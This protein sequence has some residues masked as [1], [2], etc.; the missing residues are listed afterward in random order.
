MFKLGSCKQKSA[1]IQLN[2][3][4]GIRRFY[5]LIHFSLGR[6]CTHTA[7]GS[8]IQHLTF[9][10][11]HLNERKV[12]VSSYVCIVFTEG[13]CNMYDTG[14][15]CHSNVLITGYK[16]A[17]LVLLV[18]TN[19][20][21]II[22]RLELFVFQ[23]FTGISFQYFIGFF[24]RAFFYQGRKNAVS[25]CLCQIIGIA[26]F[27]F[28]LYVCLMRVYTKCHVGRQGPRCCGP[29]QEVCIFAQNLEANNSRTLF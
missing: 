18:C 21:T 24:I 19:L 12:I 23:I 5:S 3:N 10:V 26:V 4:F 22:K 9:F 1:L 16:E 20:C 2:Q 13:R 14:T 29:C 28:Y 6:L 7:K 25:Q 15:I 17:L 8:F 27:C 11:Y